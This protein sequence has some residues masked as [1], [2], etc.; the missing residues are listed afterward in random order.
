MQFVAQTFSQDALVDVGADSQRMFQ[1]LRN[2]CGNR[3][4][5]LNPNG[6][7]HPELPAGAIW[8]GDISARVHDGDEARCCVQPFQ[9]IF[10]DAFKRVL[11]FGEVSSAACFLLY[12]FCDFLSELPFARRAL[13]AAYED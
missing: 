7:S 6:T 13:T 4:L 12:Q 3:D 1:S 8:I 9:D 2:K 10:G 5:L 11:I